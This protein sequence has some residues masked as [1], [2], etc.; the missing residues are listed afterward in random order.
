MPHKKYRS[1]SSFFKWY[2]ETILSED[3]IQSIDDLRLVDEIFEYLVL[4][5]PQDVEVLSEYVVFC[6]DILGDRKKTRIY[7]Q[8]LRDVIKEAR[9]L[10]FPTMKE[11]M[12]NLDR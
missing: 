7:S 4:R 2:C 11:I 6:K 8:L 10:A 3:K 1:K 5:N 12:E 9:K